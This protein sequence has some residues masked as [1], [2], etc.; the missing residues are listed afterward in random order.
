[1]IRP[2]DPRI[3]F[4][5]KENRIYLLALQMRKDI[6]RELIAAKEFPVYVYVEY[7]HESTDVV[8]AVMSLMRNELRQEGWLVAEDDTKALC[9]TGVASC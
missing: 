7:H 9:I 3:A 8:F 1:M 4:N 2:D 5:K 6:E